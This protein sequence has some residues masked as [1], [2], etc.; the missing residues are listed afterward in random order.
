MEQEGAAGDVSIGALTKALAKKLSHMKKVRGSL[1]LGS[2]P[3]ESCECH[4]RSAVF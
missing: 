4:V 2:S 3:R 1:R